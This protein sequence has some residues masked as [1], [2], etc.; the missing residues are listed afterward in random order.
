MK[1]ICSI[2]GRKTT[3]AAYIGAEPVGP[4]CAKKLGLQNAKPGKLGRV[5]LVK[6]KPVKAGKEPE[7]L[8]LFD[9]KSS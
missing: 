6:Y 4:G 2:C 9:E 3:P 1:P 7:N 5:T 8:D